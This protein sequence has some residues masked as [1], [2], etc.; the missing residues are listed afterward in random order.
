[1]PLVHGGA[2]ER[3]SYGRKKWLRPFAVSLIGVSE[4]VRER[5]VA[6]GVPAGRVHV[7]ENFLTDDLRPRR[8]AFRAGVERAIVVSR[9]D[10]V[11][12]VS[13]LLD[14]L[15]LAPDLERLDLSVFG[16]GW[17]EA[18]LRQRALLRHRNVI[19]SGLSFEVPTMLSQADLLVHTCPTEPF[20]L[21]VLEAMAAGIPV[22]VPDTGGPAGFVRDGVTGFVYRAN[23]AAHLARRLVEIRR[24]SAEELNR[25]VAAADALLRERFA[26]A[27]RISDYRA[28][29][30]GEAA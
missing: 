24:K 4:F 5:L 1:M 23:D 8:P 14:A 21:V 30:S 11:K 22:L 18:A 20:G 7:V 10:P 28:L 2:Q 3:L 19:F 26:P 13:L 29:I 17:E 16:T 27:K 15:E 6:N 9:L 25:I 12:R